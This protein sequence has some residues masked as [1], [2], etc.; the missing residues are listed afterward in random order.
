MNQEK[1]QHFGAE[2][3]LEDAYFRQWVLQPSAETDGFWKEFQSAYPEKQGEIAEAKQLLAMLNKHF[4]TQVNEIPATR[5]E[6]S[7]RKLQLK[8]QAKLKPVTMYQKMWF[9]W[10]VAASVLILIVASLFLFRTPEPLML[11]HSTGNGERLSIT[12]PDSSIVQMNANS[13]FHFFPEQWD[14]QDKREV[15]LDGE[16]FFSVEKKVAGTKFIVHVGEL[17]VAVLGTQ[18]NV[19]S[20]GEQA[21]VVLEEGK[22]ELSI[23]DRQKIQMEPGDYVSYSASEHQIAT[24]KVKASDYS[25]WKDGMAVFNDSLDEIVRELEILYGINFLIENEQLKERQIQ[26]SAPADS[27]EQVL[28]ILEI[29]YPAEINIELENGQVRIY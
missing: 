23:E 27:L 6:D 2:D 28:Q 7:F 11:V 1:Y 25:A 16:A 21:E 8:T 15:W 26:L 17:Q 19:R 29:M 13:N 9:R 12:L 10:S 5:A 20:R 24:R 14:E 18:F 4:E 3:F 22:I